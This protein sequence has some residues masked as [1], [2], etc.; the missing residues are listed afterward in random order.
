MWSTPAYLHYL[1]YTNID[2][3]YPNTNSPLSMSMTEP[4]AATAIS[5]IYVVFYPTTWPRRQFD[6]KMYAGS[7]QLVQSSLY[8]MRKRNVMSDSR[9]DKVDTKRERE[10]YVKW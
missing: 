9:E 10:S 2:Q 3:G 7:E 8:T 6:T 4:K 5:E 1:I